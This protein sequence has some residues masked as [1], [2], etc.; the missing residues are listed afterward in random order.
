MRILPSWL[1]TLVTGPLPAA[2]QQLADDLTLIG[3][4]V[5]GIDRSGTEPVFE[6]DIT[7]NRVDAMN[8]Y[9]IAREC[10]ALYDVELN[11]LSPKLPEPDSQ[12]TRLE[13][14]PIHIEEPSLC[15]RYTALMLREVKVQPAAGKIIERFAA[16][17]QNA[18][19]NAADATNYTLLEMGHPT[20]VFD[21]DKLAGGELRIRKARPGETITTLDGA[22]RVLFDDD[23]VIADAQKPVAIAGVIGGEATKVTETTRNI[24]IE[25]AWFDTATVRRTSRRHG[26]HTDAS[27]RFERGADYNATALACRRVAELVLQSG[28]GRLAS[29]MIDKIARK[30]E[31]APIPLGVAEVWRMLGKEIGKEEIRRILTRLGFGVEVL[32]NLDF[33]ISVPTWRLDVNR[34]IDLIEE[35]ARI[36]GFNKFANHLPAFSGGIVEL[37]TAENEMLMREGLLAL[38]YHEALSNTF[39]S[40]EDGERF[41]P[42]TTAVALANPLSEERGRMRSSLLP[43]MLDMLEHN[44]NRG[45]NEVRLFEIGNTFAA[46]GAHVEQKQSACFAATAAAVKIEADWPEQPFFQMKGDLDALLRRYEGAPAYAAKAPAYFAAGRAAAVTLG[47]TV[48]A[49]LGEISPAAYGG[50]K[51]KQPL[52]AC[53]LDL[54]R[55]FAQPLRKARYKPLSRFPAVERDFSFLLPHGIT[56]EKIQAAVQGLEMQNLRNFDI[57]ERFPW[58]SMPEGHYSA[59]LRVGFQSRERTLTDEEVGR[60]AKGIVETIANLGGILRAA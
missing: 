42:E 18:I 33:L 2:D 26:L 39:M 36:H 11:V 47:G 13:H 34:E 17:G 31:I 15:A 45:Q 30:I 1:R 60:D 29:G 56:W 20:H 14:F 27:H 49:A 4:A 28:G 35:I 51:F 52:Y 32:G 38:G 3:V 21:L 24:L 16:L 44:L 41:T 22:E 7:T 50:R 40:R 58:K 59:L 19:N 5:E 6:M 9:G 8:H 12:V 48:I 46:S 54:D 55:L 23:L 57:V 10:S 37:P 53:E 43:G 25:S